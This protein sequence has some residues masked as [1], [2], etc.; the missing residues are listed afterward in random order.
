MR[1][2]T[3]LVAGIDARRGKEKCCSVG[4]GLWHLEPG[5]LRLLRLLLLLLLL[6]GSG[7]Q[8]PR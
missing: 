3:I 5:D 7:L 2:R 1:K 4:S 6:H 8:R